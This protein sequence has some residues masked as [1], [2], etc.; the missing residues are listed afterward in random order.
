MKYNKVRSV[1]RATRN[2]KLMVNY[3][4]YNFG[5]REMI[6]SV[7]SVSRGMRMEL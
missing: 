7:I 5:V 1:W 6:F 3:G 2:L 4:L